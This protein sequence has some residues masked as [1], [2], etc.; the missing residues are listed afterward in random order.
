[1]NKKLTL[2]DLEELFNMEQQLDI[3]MKDRFH[4]TL[5][6]EQLSILTCNKGSYPADEENEID[7]EKLINT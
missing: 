7:N 4:K 6:D 5:S 3:P 1:M 2:K